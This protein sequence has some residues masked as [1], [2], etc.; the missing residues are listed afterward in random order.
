MWL[1]Y[2]DMRGSENSN[3]K[4]M[5]TPGD[6]RGRDMQQGRATRHQTST[7]LPNK[8]V[9]LLFCVPFYV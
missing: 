6:W 5:I 3:F 8:H 4:G 7:C 9:Y 2:K 1:K